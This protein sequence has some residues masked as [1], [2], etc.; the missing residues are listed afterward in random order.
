MI[1]ERF[2]LYLTKFADTGE[3]SE[4][5][6]PRVL[7]TAV[8][9]FSE[10]NDPREILQLLQQFGVRDNNTIVGWVQERIDSEESNKLVSLASKRYSLMRQQNQG[11]ATYEEVCD[12]INRNDNNFD[13]A[14]E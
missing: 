10:V 4:N 8:L 7:K 9:K 11:E 5:F 14:L 13:R 3:K 2:N 6:I 12:V 1:I